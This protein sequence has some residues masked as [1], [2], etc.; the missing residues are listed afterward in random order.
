MTSGVLICSDLRFRVWDVS[1]SI[2]RF[3][4]FFLGGGSVRWVF[5][6]EFLDLV[7]HGRAFK[8]SD[9][10]HLCCSLYV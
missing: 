5:L 7:G 10:F 1:L 2:G 9:D 6:L 4:I 8:A 3:G